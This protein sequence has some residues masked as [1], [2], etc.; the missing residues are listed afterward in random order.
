M[1]DKTKTSNITFLSSHQ[2]ELADGEY[3]FSVEQNIT[4]KNYVLGVATD[5]PAH[6]FAKTLTINVAGPK[7]SLAPSE[8]HSVFPPVGGSG[9]YQANFPTITLTR[10]TL[11]WERKPFDLYSGDASWL[12]LLMVDEDK[13]SYIQEGSKLITDADFPSDIFTNYGINKTDKLIDVKKPINCITVNAGAGIRSQ[14][15]KTLNRLK[16]L[17][18][19]RIKSDENEEH[20]VIMSRC[21]PKAGKNTTMYLIS[22]ENLF[23]EDLT[24]N[25]HSKGNLK[26]V[27]AGRSFIYLHKWSFHSVK[28]QL[29]SFGMGNLNRIKQDDR[30]KS[31]DFSTIKDEDQVYSTKEL[32]NTAITEIT[33]DVSLI[34][35]LH[36]Y[37]KL[38]GTTFHEVMSNLKNGVSVLR[39][40][41]TK[42]QSIESSGSVYLPLQI[43]ENE[44]PFYDYAL[45]R[46]ALVAKP[47]KLNQAVFSKDSKLHITM[48]KLRSITSNGLPIFVDMTNGFIPQNG[49]ELALS[50]NNQKD[51]SYATAYEI[52]K[53]TALNDNDFSKAFYE[54]KHDVATAKQLNNMPANLQASHLAAMHQYDAN[55]ALPDSVKKKFDNW[56]LLIGLPARYLIPSPEMFPQESLRYFVIDKNWVNAF[57]CGAFSIGH[58]LQ[59]D[60]SKELTNLILKD[61]DNYYGFILNSLAVQAWPDY[62]LEV[63]AGA[64]KFLVCNDSS[65]DLKRKQNLDSSTCIYI[66]DKKFDTLKFHLQSGKLHPGFMYENNTYLKD[67]LP[68]I[69]DIHEGDAFQTSPYNDFTDCLKN[70]VLQLSG[71]NSVINKFKL[72]FGQPLTVPQFNACMMEGTPEV[73]FTLGLASS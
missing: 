51:L 73:V 34:K 32:F 40:P 38:P 65:S 18:Y 12:F 28:D 25:N 23:D 17:S 45:Y 15:P 58:T 24:G 10:S 55:K 7:F 70:G 5:E 42:P 16:Y 64:T 9:D 22:L 60:F 50:I 26:S 2:P 3:V 36:N 14:I 53:L 1:P 56:K 11:P 61:T 66:F 4:A 39:N 57:I 63:L 29:Y 30:L 33:A 62:E 46:G 52:G 20:A 44:M 59:A 48:D 43:V 69:I 21:L 71:N 68:D 54:W 6:H 27:A 49:E 8:I 13:K 35:L 31:L 47:I 41:N 67:T 37:C 19:A 72:I